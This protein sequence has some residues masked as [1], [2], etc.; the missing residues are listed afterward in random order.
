MRMNERTNEQAIKDA[1]AF[2][3]YLSYTRQESVFIHS[4]N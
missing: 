1:S 4:L 2:M 3:T